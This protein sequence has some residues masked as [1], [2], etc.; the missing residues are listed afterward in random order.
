[1]NAFTNTFHGFYKPLRIVQP[2]VTS[3]LNASLEAGALLD[4]LDMTGV[5]R[6]NLVPVDW[7]SA[8]MTRIILDPGLHGA[9]YHLTSTRPTSVAL[10][11]RVFEQ[12]VVEM[13]KRPAQAG[14]PASGFDPLLLTRLFGDQ[15][16]VYRSYW[17][18]DP[19]F[20]VSTTLRAV[21]DLPAPAIDEPVIRRLCRFAI[22]TQ[23]RW[24]PVGRDG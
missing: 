9:T 15:M 1:V 18:D 24:P 13:A 10:L 12:M 2:F 3:F 5:E 16:Q 23:F 4:V 7:V 22:H 17:R 20:D 8:V 6:K 19:E 14:R 21:P 11:C